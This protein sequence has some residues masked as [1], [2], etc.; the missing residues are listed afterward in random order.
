MNTF[1]YSPHFQDG[2]DDYEELNPMVPM[3]EN[4]YSE[5]NLLPNIPI[6]GTLR[7]LIVSMMMWKPLNDLYS[8]E[9]F[10]SWFLFFDLKKI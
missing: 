2:D 3:E 9:L 10:S 8:K 5:T 6:S 1:E 7:E 4:Q